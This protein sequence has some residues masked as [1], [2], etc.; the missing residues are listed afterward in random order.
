MTNVNSSGF[1]IT[2]NNNGKSNVVVSYIAIGKRKGYEA[3]VLASEVIAAD[4]TAKLS[5]GLHNDND[6]EMTVM[7]CSMKMVSLSLEIHPSTLPDPNKKVM[8]EEMLPQQVL[9]QEKGEHNEQREE[10]ILKDPAPEEM[11]NC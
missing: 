4:Y 8:E 9:P 1:S 5:E 10:M 3:S 2:E 6:M 7:V 11:Q